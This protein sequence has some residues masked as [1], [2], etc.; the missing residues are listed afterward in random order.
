MLILNREKNNFKLIFCNTTPIATLTQT[1]RNSPGPHHSAGLR[2][3][4]VCAVSLLP[5]GEHHP[6]ISRAV[7][8]PSPVIFCGQREGRSYVM[9]CTE[10]RIISCAMTSTNF[11]K[12]QS[13]QHTVHF[14]LSRMWPKFDMCRCLFRL[15][16]SELSSVIEILVGKESWFT[17]Q[18]CYSLYWILSCYCL[19][20]FEMFSFSEMNIYIP[21]R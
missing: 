10:S 21:H 8:R 20:G 4:D 9:A 2:N 3:A 6:H 12:A 15:P 11:L 1:L 18:L 5:C 19:F 17:L 7:S 13:L 14:F 16:S